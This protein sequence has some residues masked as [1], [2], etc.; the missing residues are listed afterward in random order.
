M[1][2][3]QHIFAGK[4]LRALRSRRGMRQA[5]MAGTLG[6]SVSYLSQLESDDRPLTPPLIAALTRHFDLRLDDLGGDSSDKRAEALRDKVE[7]VKNQPRKP[8]TQLLDKAKKAA[9]DNRAASP[10]FDRSAS[11]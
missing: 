6:I 7:G 1:D 5:E 4:T 8:P 10:S 11:R 2:R 3:P 9:R